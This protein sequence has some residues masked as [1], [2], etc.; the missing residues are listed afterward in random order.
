MSLNAEM[1]AFILGNLE[2]IEQAYATLMKADELL[3]ANMAKF[4]RKIL[5]ERD[6]FDIHYME[7][8]DLGFSRS[9]WERNDQD[10]PLLVFWLDC[11]G[12]NTDK[13]WLSV[14][15][16]KAPGAIAGIYGWYEW[17]A[18][19]IKRKDWKNFLRDFFA[20]HESLHENGFTLNADGTAIMK[21]L[22]LDLDCLKE[23]FLS[24]EKCFEPVAEALEAIESQV[25]VFDELSKGAG[26]L[27]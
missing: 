1:G 22:I 12:E 23:N 9:S 10:K 3:I 21:P 8:G 25:E 6:I 11:Q 27:V 19:G 7:D 14:L 13:T 18:K 24:S 15:G 16:G 20:S 26:K 2:L 4:A 17:S 5:R